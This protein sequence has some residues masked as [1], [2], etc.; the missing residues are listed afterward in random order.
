LGFARSRVGHKAEISCWT[1]Q[2]HFFRHLMVS[3]SNVFVNPTCWSSI[4]TIRWS[5]R[6]FCSSRSLNK[7]SL[8]LLCFRERLIMV[9]KGGSGPIF[10]GFVTNLTKSFP[11]S[12]LGSQRSWPTNFSTSSPCISGHNFTAM[13]WLLPMTGWAWPRFNILRLSRGRVQESSCWEDQHL[14]F[15]ESYTLQSSS[16]RKLDF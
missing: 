11:S 3:Q 1:W 13:A 2:V 7:C 4:G 15:S 5:R 9:G 10:A 8:I 12:Y 6:C 14:L 16:N